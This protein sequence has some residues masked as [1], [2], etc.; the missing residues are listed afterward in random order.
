M[1][2]NDVLKG[3]ARTDVV[4]I[5]PE[6]TVRELVAQLAEHNVGALLVSA[7]G[8]GIGGFVSERGVGRWLGAGLGV[9]DQPVAAIR[10]SRVQTC[11][12]AD[13]VTRMMLVMT[14]HRVRQVPVV[15]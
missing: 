14:V 6:A 2:I 5:R 9:L 12:G 7:D 1:R 10:T 13:E 3:K 15:S 4:T 8:S 11:E